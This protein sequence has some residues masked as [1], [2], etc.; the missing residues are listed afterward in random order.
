LIEEVAGN[1]EQDSKKKDFVISY[2]KC[3]W[4][5]SLLAVLDTPLPLDLCGTLN[6]LKKIL[7]HSYEAYSNEYQDR[8]QYRI[9]ISTLIVIIAEYFRP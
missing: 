1:L 8:D 9:M 5:Y 3:T 2:H 6:Q 4:I 7:I